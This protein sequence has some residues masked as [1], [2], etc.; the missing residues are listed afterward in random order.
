MLCRTAKQ[1]VKDDKLMMSLAGVV[2]VIVVYNRIAI[3]VGRMTISNIG[4]CINA[5]AC[6]NTNVRI[7]G[8]CEFTVGVI[9]PI[10]VDN[11]YVLQVTLVGV[12]T[13]CTSPF[14]IV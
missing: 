7:A 1:L 14:V 13:V 3:S 10:V 8:A 4:I 11:S 6:L 12:A 9:C 2:Y 5:Y